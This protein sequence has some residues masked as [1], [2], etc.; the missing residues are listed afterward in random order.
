MKSTRIPKLL[1]HLKRKNASATRSAELSRKEPVMRSSLS[2]G[3]DNSAVGNL[4]PAAEC[5][6]PPEYRQALVSIATNVWRARTKMLDAAGEVRDE[7]KRVN[8]H[9][10]AIYRD[11]VEV[12]IVIRD[13]TGDAYDEGQPMEVV[14]CRPTEGLHKKRVTETLLPSIFLNNQLLQNGE[15][16]IAIPC[17][18]D[19]PAEPP[20]R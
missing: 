3:D 2:S 16:E 15:I 13:H 11:L 10:E 14:A 8:R 19:S 9:I 5:G 18:P 12:G 7:M 1:E 6:L 20:E 4:L 17:T